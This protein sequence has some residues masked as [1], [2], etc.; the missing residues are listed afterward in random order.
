[1]TSTE[2]RSRPRWLY[3]MAAIVAIWMTAPPLV[4]IPMS[5]ASERTLTFPPSGYSLRW[6]QEFFQNP[7]W[8]DALRSSLL[9][10]VL[11]MVISVVIGTLGA[12]AVV[13]G[14]F[15]GRGL[16][17]M[18]GIAPLV[19][20]IVVLGIGVYAM[21]L[22]WGLIGT[23]PGFVA[24]HCVLA[25]PYVMIT[26][27][28]ALRVVDG[29]LERAAQVLGARPH[30]VFL[31]VTLPLIAPGMLAGG[32]FAFVTSFDEVVV[33][34]FIVSP[35]LRTL[36][37][38]MYSSVTRDINPTIAAASTLILLV[39]TVLILV[40]TKFLFSSSSDGRSKR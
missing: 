15:R 17:E 23:V 27:G 31:R 36:P 11:V 34:L 37:V 30:R 22:R 2:T 32:L 25:V 16:L 33:S 6:Y 38:E 5:F 1:M 7:V 19:V 24:A 40:S 4:V 21:F 28:S 39:S 26:V 12:F 8:I 13:R 9:I 10:A 3:L 35:G 29:Q 18:V 14:R 20:P